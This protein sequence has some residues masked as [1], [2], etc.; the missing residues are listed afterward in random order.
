M[1]SS[2]PRKEKMKIEEMY[3]YRADDGRW[4]F[5][6]ESNRPIGIFY[7]SSEKATDAL[8]QYMELATPQI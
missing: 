2:P 7:D 5:Y 4:S 8:Y 1:M 3:I 6:D